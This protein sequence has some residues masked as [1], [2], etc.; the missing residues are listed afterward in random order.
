MSEAIRSGLLRT[1]TLHMPLCLSFS[2]LRPD[3]LPVPPIA[4]TLVGNGL[5]RL[6]VD[7]NDIFAVHRVGVQD[8]QGVPAVDVG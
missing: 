5:R 1:L 8:A 3:V 6:L 4:V 7:K 2:P